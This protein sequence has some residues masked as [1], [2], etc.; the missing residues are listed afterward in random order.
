MKAEIMY[1]ERKD[2]LNGDDARIGRVTRSKTGATL[3]YQDLEFRSLKGGYKA[4]YFEVKSGQTYWISGC[5]RD[6]ADRLY[7]SG[8]PVWIDEDVRKEYWE[9]IRNRPDL[10]TRDRT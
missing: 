5:R 8:K 9:T 7:D 3:Y 6:G 2:Q 1:I 10:V 4:N